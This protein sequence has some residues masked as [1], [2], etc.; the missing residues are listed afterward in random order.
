MKIVSESPSETKPEAQNVSGSPK[1]DIEND[2]LESI[3]KAFKGKARG[4]AR[5][6]FVR[7]QNRPIVPSLD[8]DPLPFWNFFFAAS[9]A[10][11]AKWGY[12]LLLFYTRSI[13]A[14]NVLIPCNHILKIVQIFALKYR[15]Y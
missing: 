11:D 2:V 7:G 8:Q 9:K 13:C 14:E 10:L 1:K 12:I 4:V 5:F 15:K 3:P 6:F